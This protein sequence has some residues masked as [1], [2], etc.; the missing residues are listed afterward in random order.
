MEGIALCPAVEGGRV[1]SRD[2]CIDPRPG[3]VLARSFE[4]PITIK[5]LRRTAFSVVFCPQDPTNT[6][7]V[8]Y[9]QTW[10]LKTWVKALDGAQ[11]LKRA[12]Q[13][14]GG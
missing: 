7:A 13:K 11:V 4:H 8:C 3:D 9:E 2:P 1:M 10:R 12:A 14:G 5:V 6:T